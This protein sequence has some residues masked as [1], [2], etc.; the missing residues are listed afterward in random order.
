M[1]M[2]IEEFYDANEQ[3]R[4]SEELEFGATWRDGA[5]NSFELNYVVDTG[6]VYLMAM[7]DAEM[8]EDPFGD[9]AVDQNEPI[10]DL[11]VEVIAVVPTVDEL[12]KALAGWEQEMTEPSSGDWARSALRDYP[13][14]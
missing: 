4:E 10:E 12:H 14:T 8:I 13:V 5:G 2:D 11:T 7:P 1:S 6:E 9:I 3:R